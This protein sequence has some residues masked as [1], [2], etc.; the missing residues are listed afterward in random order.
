M[1]SFILLGVFVIL[2][3]FLVLIGVKVYEGVTQ[4]SSANGEIRSTLSYLSNKVRAFDSEGGVD[5]EDKNGIGVLSLH[6]TI[7]DTDYVTYIYQKNGAIYEYFTEEEGDLP[8][9]RVK[10]SWLYP[11]FP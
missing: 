2:S 9:K 6:Q 5:I 3:L 7:K 4:S 11:I 1:F 8:P 10:K